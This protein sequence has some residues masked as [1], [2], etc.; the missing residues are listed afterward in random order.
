MILIEEYLTK[1]QVDRQAHLK[2]DEAC[3]ERGANSTQCR[4]LLAYV[5]NTSIPKGSKIHCCHACN[6]AKCSNPYHLY[7]GTSQ[8]NIKDS[9]N[10]GTRKP[11]VVH[12][13]EHYQQLGKTHGS[14][15]GLNNKGKPKSEAHKEKIRQTLLSKSRLKEEAR[16]SSAIR[17]RYIEDI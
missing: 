7:W 17:Q 15:G 6:N 1:S 10:S 3:D 8:E 2:L 14:K 11:N 5:L 13:K 4:A 9:W 16:L 12:P